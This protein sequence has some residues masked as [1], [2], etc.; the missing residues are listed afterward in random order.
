MN[1]DSPGFH[2][3]PVGAAALTGPVLF[4]VVFMTW[5]LFM[6]LTFLLI[7]AGLFA[8]AYRWHTRH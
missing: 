8:G 3:P 2:E 7:G 5:R 1:L 4:F 6:K